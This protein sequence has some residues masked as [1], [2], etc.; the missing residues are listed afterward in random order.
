MF[1]TPLIFH[2]ID[3]SASQ[4]GSGLAVSALIGTV[5]RLLS[6][7]L[8]DRGVRCSWPVR[9][10]T[11]LAIAADCILIN[12][13]SYGGYLLGQLLLG[14][15]AGLYW[16]AIELAV[17]LSCGSVSSGKGYAL[18]RSADALGIGLGALIGT[19]AAAVDALRVVYVV[20]A[21][22]MGAVLVLIS[23]QPLMDG[24]TV[25]DL[26]RAASTAERGPS[27]ASKTW[28]LP[29]LPVL[30]IS[31]VATGILAL[32][33]SAL[34]LDLVRGGLQRPGLSESHSSALIALQLT[35][36]VSLQWPVGRWLAERSVA[37]GLGLSL[38]GFSLGCGLIAI[39]SLFE[40]GTALVLLALLPMAFAQAAFLPTATEAVIEETPPEHRGLAMALFSQCFA[41]SAIVA[42]LAGGAL[43]DAQNNGLMLWLLMGLGCLLM[44]PALRNLKPRYR[45]SIERTS[46]IAVPQQDAEAVAGPQNSP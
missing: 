36:L 18:V 29:L 32:Q 21:F 30:A 19:I 24:P 8:L 22:C 16:P 39:S 25:R 35:L 7:A 31:I 5:V 15:A 23:L 27:T 6:G 26:S 4:V 10:T 33:Q 40:S 2:A 38:A 11:L 42:P 13:D 3:F 34:P 28:L 45:S 44:L 1:M 14:S 9:V 17:P 41:V 46:T 20:E 37:F 43:L 12:A